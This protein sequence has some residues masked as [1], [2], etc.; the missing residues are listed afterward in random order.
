MHLEGKNAIVTG[1]AQGIGKEIALR[2]AE[3]G[4]NI[5][6]CDIMEDAVA[7]AAG[8]ISAETGAVAKGFKVNVAESDEVNDFVKTVKADYGSIDVLVNNAGIARDNM[9]FRMS[10]DEFDMV[11]KVNMYSVFYFCRAVGRVMAKQ[12]GG[13]IINI[14]SVIGVMGNAG[15]HNYAASKA[16]VIGLTKSVAK[17]LAGRGVRANAIAPGFIETAMTDALPEDIKETYI[18]L[19][20]LGRMGTPGD[21]ADVVGF[22]A[23]DAS[24]YITGQVLLVDGGMIMA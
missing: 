1:G 21:I 10:D 24:S 7:A 16:G 4:C 5:A 3:H 23:G 8:E 14:S 22:L 17:E 12:H 6:V 20:P 13:S 19:I 11:Q 18:G 9:L 15:Q 2:L